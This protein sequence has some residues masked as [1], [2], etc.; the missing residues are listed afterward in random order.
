LEENKDDA[1]EGGEAAKK[2]KKKKKKSGKGGGASNVAYAPREQDNSEV[3]L[4]GSWKPGEWKQTIDYSIP[5]AE[6]YP[7]NVFP[8]GEWME[9]PFDFNTHRIGSKELRQKDQLTAS[10]VNELR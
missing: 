3:R 5:V 8:E 1:E 6:Q 9:H 7:D 4:L 10:M 2:K